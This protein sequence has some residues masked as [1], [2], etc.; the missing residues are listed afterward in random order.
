MNNDKD[1]RAIIYTD[2]ST[3]PTN[4][5]KSGAGI[6][7]YIYD[8]NNNDNI[9]INK[10]S[11]FIVTNNGYKDLDSAINSIKAA[12]TFKEIAANKPQGFSFIVNPI[13]YIEGLVSLSHATNN[14][15]ELVGALEAVKFIVNNKEDYPINHVTIFTDSGYAINAFNKIHDSINEKYNYWLNRP[16]YTQLREIESALKLAMANNIKVEL[17]WIKGHAGSI[18]NVKADMMADIGRKLPTDD[19]SV[20]I[21]FYNPKEY[22]GKLYIDSYIS[23]NMDKLI[24]DK[25]LNTK[26]LGYTFGFK[27]KVDKAV[28]GKSLKHNSYV[29]VKPLSAADSKKLTKKSITKEANKI[30]EELIEL[31]YNNHFKFIGEDK[32][33]NLTVL[34]NLEELIKGDSY[35]YLNRYGA[36]CAVELI[37]N[38]ID[39]SRVKAKIAGDVEHHDTIADIYYSPEL[40]DEMS[41]YNIIQYVTVE[42]FVDI[43]MQIHSGS[44]GFNELNPVAST[45]SLDITDSIYKENKLVLKNETLQIENDD[46]LVNLVTGINVPDLNLLKKYEKKVKLVQLNIMSNGRIFIVFHL[47]DV[48]IV[49]FN[50]MTIAY[51][52]TE[53]IAIGNIDTTVHRK[54]NK[55]KK[56]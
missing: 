38:R 9:T 14:V 43:L 30:A 2:G 37:K 23:D 33:K 55:K 47:E 50:P 3:A 24:F 52:K 46:L 49:Y 12:I 42:P 20:K 56:K 25:C 6:H 45:N 4:P 7:G 41:R 11:R 36:E 40:E 48:A 5:G 53:N 44:Y 39:L 17:R 21:D 35:S 29:M 8:Y 19:I 32:K 54:I 13:D 10:P 1:L 22:Y 28:A 34:L 51:Y 31:S 15:A 27:K 26:S 16:N 18:G